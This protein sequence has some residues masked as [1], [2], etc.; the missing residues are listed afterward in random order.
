MTILDS[1]GC[2]SAEQKTPLRPSPALSRS[3]FNATMEALSFFKLW[4]RTLLKI[5]RGEAELLRIP[6]PA[7]FLRIRTGV[8][9]QCSFLC[10]EGTR[11]GPGAV[12]VQSSHS[13]S[14][15]PFCK[16]LA[17]VSPPISIVST[18]RGRMCWEPENW[19]SVLPRATRQ[20]Q[21]DKVGATIVIGLDLDDGSRL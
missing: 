2:F 17:S 1:N 11:L 7:V 16:W 20:V 3:I 12:S 15:S 21:K 4:I 5:D 8:G 19:Q 18:D 13:F 9:F 14:F 10:R 6:K